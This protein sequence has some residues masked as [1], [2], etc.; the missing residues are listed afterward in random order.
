ML[1]S[2]FFRTI[3]TCLP[4]FSV[5]DNALQDVLAECAPGCSESDRFM[6]YGMLGPAPKMLFK[7]LTEG[8]SRTMWVALFPTWQKMVQ[9]FNAEY[10]MFLD[11]YSFQA[12]GNTLLTFQSASAMREPGP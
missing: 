1:A 11:F 3:S 8:A 6:V 9:M 4:R 7:N 10:G 12:S 5:L 2:F